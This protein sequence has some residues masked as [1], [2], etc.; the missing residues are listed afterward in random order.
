MKHIYNEDY[1]LHI[2]QNTQSVNNIMHNK[3][4]SGKN[5]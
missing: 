5:N 4:Q 3:S 1:N 2:I